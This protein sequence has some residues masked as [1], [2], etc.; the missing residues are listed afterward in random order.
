MSNLS[1]LQNAVGG[2]GST[3]L[4]AAG[5]ALG[6]A[7]DISGVVGGV[8]S[9]ISLIGS[10]N[11]HDT[12]LSDILSEIQSDF[13][14]LESQIR[15]E[16]ILQ[17]FRDLDQAISG[18]IAVLGSLEADLTQN[19]PLTDDYRQTQIQTCFES[20]HRTQQ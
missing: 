16:D 5:A 9:I 4:N 13:Q 7:A 19:P 15:T 1:D 8:T 2:K 14:Q 3:A 20:A 17:R 11:S 10:I 6:L 18:A 12:T